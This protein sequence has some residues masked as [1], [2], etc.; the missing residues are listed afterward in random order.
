MCQ[1][2]EPSV[3]Y[4]PPQKGNKPQTTHTHTKTPL[5]G[6]APDSSPLVRRSLAQVQVGCLK[7]TCSC[8]SKRDR[9]KY[10]V[11]AWFPST[12]NKQSGTNSKKRQTQMSRQVVSAWFPFPT[13]TTPVAP[14]QQK[15]EHDR[16]S[17]RNR[18]GAVSCVPSDPP[19]HSI[20]GRL[21]AWGRQG[22]RGRAPH[23]RPR[24]AG[25]HKP[26]AKP[27]RRPRREMRAPGFCFFLDGFGDTP[28]KQELKP[29]LLNPR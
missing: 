13:N 7:T 21:E 10:V 1:N 27:T 18:Q 5:P 26:A 24:S 23:S 3:G 12:T 14:T 17:S 4:P 2:R 16:T 28:F 19:T 8:L 20:R 11:S 22:G 15:T 25:A 6:R 9:P 29:G